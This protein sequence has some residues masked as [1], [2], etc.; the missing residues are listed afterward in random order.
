MTAAKHAWGPAFRVDVR[1]DRKLARVVP[2]GELDIATAPELEA[3]LSAVCAAGFTR[4]V[5]DLGELTFIDSTGLRVVMAFV[6]LATRGGC[7][8]ELL[9]G[10]DQVQRVFTIS[11]V[12]A[13]L[14][15]SE[16]APRA[17]ASPAQP[18]RAKAPRHGPQ[19]PARATRVASLAR[20]APSS[21][22]AA[23]GG[24]SG[25]PGHPPAM[26]ADARER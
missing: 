7:E 13:E 9:P 11:G 17:H 23:A 19:A 20:A 8:I 4:I 24:P 21:A 5:L 15:F 2:V 14:P 12:L 18:G 22:G 3:Q 10:P 25:S 1:P 16:G 26:R 6:G